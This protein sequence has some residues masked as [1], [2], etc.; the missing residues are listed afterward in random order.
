MLREKNVNT[1]CHLLTQINIKRNLYKQLYYL[2]NRTMITEKEKLETLI[3]IEEGIEYFE[4]QIAETKW[5][6]EF[7]IGLEFKSISEENTYRIH[8][9]NMCIERLN[10]RLTKQLFAIRESQIK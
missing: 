7:G 5:S 10:E 6:N 3:T 4:N 8:T 9:Y 2:I 1:A